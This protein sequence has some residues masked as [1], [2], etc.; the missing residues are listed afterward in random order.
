[1]CSMSQKLFDI[2]TFFGNQSSLM[3]IMLEFI[4]TEDSDASLVFGEVSDDSPQIP[5]GARTGNQAIDMVLS[6][7]GKWQ[8]TCFT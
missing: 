5:S 7:I 3:S 1:M 6:R 2:A 4:S 8:S